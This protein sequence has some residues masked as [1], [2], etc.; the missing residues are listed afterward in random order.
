MNAS[1]NEDV[2]D[3]SLGDDKNVNNLVYTPMVRFLIP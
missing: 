2:N 1:L 3:T